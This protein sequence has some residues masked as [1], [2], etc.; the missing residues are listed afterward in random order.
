MRTT[1]TIDDA[2]LDAAKRLAVAERRSV[3]SVVEDAMRQMLARRAAVR[4][5]QPFALDVFDGGAYQPGVD[6]A[7]NA[8]L[9][10]VLEAG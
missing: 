2:L 5:A 6:I 8:R 9:L 1:L 10:D 7:D 4:D 3:S